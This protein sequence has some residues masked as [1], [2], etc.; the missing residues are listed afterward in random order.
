MIL[1]TELKNLIIINKIVEM[2]IEIITVISQI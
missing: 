2:L 1:I